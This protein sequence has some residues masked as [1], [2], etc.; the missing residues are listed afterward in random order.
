MK[1]YNSKYDKYHRYNK[2][3]LDFTVDFVIINDIKAKIEE[4]SN[5]GQFRYL[6]TSKKLI[7]EGGINMGKLSYSYSS[8][9]EAYLELLRFEQLLLNTYSQCGVGLRDK[10]DDPSAQNY[11]LLL[12]QMI[13]TTFAA[14]I[15]KA[16]FDIRSKMTSTE[17][18]YF[19]ISCPENKKK[20]GFGDDREV[21]SEINNILFNLSKKI[22][23]SHYLL[24]KSRG[25]PLL[26]DSDTYTIIHFDPTNQILA[27]IANTNSHQ[28][29]LLFSIKF[30]AFYLQEIYPYI[31]K[32]ENMQKS[33]RSIDREKIQQYIDDKFSL[34]VN[35]IEEKKL[36]ILERIQEDNTLIKSPQEAFDYIK[37]MTNALMMLRQS[38]LPSEEKDEL[39]TYVMQ[40][41]E[42]D[43][44]T[45]L[46]TLNGKSVD[47]IIKEIH[48]MPI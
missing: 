3:A 11:E 43:L 20:F 40:Q 35:D 44:A 29:S 47:Q 17:K 4:L 10:L 34:F 48:E 45:Y 41:S 13:T 31:E 18:E 38:D 5:F 36:A 19:D 12:E 15:Q 28:A 37:D 21:I 1:K 42:I 26:Y 23:K 22:G 6:P 7:F 14:E 30:E 32:M 33:G 8:H 39:W 46:S 16:D 27:P 25:Y 9:N 2:N 24:S